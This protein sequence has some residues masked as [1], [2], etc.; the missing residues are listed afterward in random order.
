MLGKN[1]SVRARHPG[2]SLMEVLVA[3]LITVIIVTVAYPSYLGIVRKSRR[4]EALEALSLIQLQ[5]ERYRSNNTSY[6][7][8]AQLGFSATTQNGH[9][10]LSIANASATGYIASAT[11]VAGS[12][13]VD[14]KERGTSCA[15]LQ[16][17]QDEPVYTP[18]G[19][20]A[21][22]SR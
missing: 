11:A 5:Q 15:I 10:A 19:Q 2:F 12:S 18:A 21:C 4:A 8:L 20:A 9:Y 7:D 14:D 3:M 1:T 13:Q 17:N 6:A 16:V 22:W